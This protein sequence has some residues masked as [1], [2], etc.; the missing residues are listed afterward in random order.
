M[1]AELLGTV[2]VRPRGSLHP[3]TQLRRDVEDIFLGIGYEIRRRTARSRRSTTSSTRS[4]FPAPHPAR[5]PRDTFYVDADT[6][7][8]T[9]T[10]P[11]QIH[12][13]EEKPPPV[14]MVSLGRFYRRDATTPTQLPDLPPVRRARDRPRDHDRRSEGNAA[15]RAAALFGE[16]REVRFRTHYFPFTEP[17]MEPHVSCGVCGGSGCPMCKWS[18]W[19][20]IGGSGMIDPQVLT[21]VGL[22]PEEWGASRSAWASSAWLSS[23]TTSRH[24]AVLGE[25]PPLP[26]AVPMRVPLS[27]LREYTDVDASAEE[28][29]DALSITAAEVNTIERRGPADTTR[30]RRRARA[31]GGQAPERR[32]APALHRRRGGGRAGADRLR[33]V[34]LRRGR[35]G[36]GG[37]AGRDA[38]E[39]ADARAARA[40]RPD[41]RGDDPR[42][43][44]GRARHR[45]RR[46]HAPARRSRARLAARRRAAADRGDPRR[47]G[48]REP[49]RSSLGLRLGAR[50]GRDLRR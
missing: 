13:L 14:Y 31:H 5:S 2:R 7:L 26:E 42:R 40:A 30:L 44:R 35:D 10:S 38:A 22:D 37:A 43:G 32:P 15:A 50:G 36:R 21:I 41:V 18:G 49:R 27:W 8:R 17:S 47:R 28:I 25:R 29:A 23:A 48:D 20:E 24:Q 45:P 1:P 34:E 3:T 46:D 16:E 9:E 33:R 19:I 12:I 4:T 39:R 6:V 11:S